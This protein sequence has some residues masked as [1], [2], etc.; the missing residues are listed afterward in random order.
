MP[1]EQRLQIKGLFTHPNELS[2][3]PN[4]A[5]VVADNIVIDEESIAAP[6]RGL[7][8][9]VSVGDTTNKIFEYQDKIIIHYGTASMGYIDGGVLT[10]YSGTFTPV[11]TDTKIKAAEQNENFYFTTQDGIKKLDAFN[12]T[13]LE[14]G[15]PRGLTVEGALT[16]ASGFLPDT[17]QV[18]YR[19]VWGYEDAND[20]LVLGAP[21][22]RVVVSNAAGG[23]RDVDLTVTIP[24]D[25][26]SKFF[27]QIYRSVISDN[28]VDPG[29]ELGLVAEFFP[30]AGELTAGS[31]TYTDSTPDGL[32]G[33]TIYTAPS[34]EGILQ[35]NEQPPRAKDITSHKNFMWYANTVSR[36]RATF[37]I[38]AADGGGAP[39]TALQVD[40]VITIAGT[41]YTGKASTNVANAEFA[42]STA[43][44]PAQR[45]DETARELVKVI[46]QH[47]GNTSVYAY[48]ISG[49]EDLP[50]QILV[51]E[52]NFGG[53][54]FTISFTPQVVNANPFAPQLPLT[55][56]NDEFKNGLYFSKNEQAEAVPTTNLLFVGSA[57]EEILRV[58][59]LRDSLFVLKED[60]IY[61]VT[62]ESA[63]SFRVDLFDNTA[64]LLGPET[65]VSISNQIMM[66]SDQGVISVTETGVTV[67]SRPIEKDLLA[68]LGESRPNVIKY[69][70]AVS[71]ESERKYIF[72]TIRTSA[73]SAATQSY[74]YNVFTNSWT[75]WDYGGSTGFV[76]ETNVENDELFIGSGIFLLKERKSL[77]YKDFADFGKDVEITAVNNNI[78]TVL[79]PSGIER[80]DILWQTDLLFSI[81]DSVDINTGEITLFYTQSFTVGT[82]RRIY[83][84]I[85]C[86]I[87]WVPFTGG[88]PGMR[89]HHREVSYLF[90]KDITATARAGFA[91]DISKN[92]EY[93]DIDAPQLFTGWGLFPWGGAPW[94]GN[95]LRR[96]IRTYIPLE[97]QRCSQLNI[98]FVHSIGFSQFKLSGLTVTFE[99]NSERLN[100]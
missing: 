6:R 30:T 40:D 71:Y 22:E 8:R 12:G 24:D 46:N 5:L 18:A 37:T 79:D 93:V 80:G 95:S 52:R 26:D 10:A 41:D 69:S 25:I 16:G 63:T 78:V 57:Q 72:S 60:G 29:E 48:Y 90:K 27:L 35:A 47:T 33:A 23:S 19:V 50:G 76:V 65:A 61:R 55:S 2:E 11:D 21:S 88:N 42:V 100:K 82:G 32:T 45:I 1:Q 67:I 98:K 97:K 9:F 31:L 49:A 20:S 81:V 86:E 70:F 92:F 89:D 51:E 54:A 73:D 44:T 99:P 85:N 7:D 68:L 64:K 58:I 83:K 13:V 3:V 36:H 53:A 75:R 56:T 38:L 59:E 4:G 96:A 39:G 43:A 17:K 28:T 91:S 34:Q 74:V 66:F 14:A 94:G 87:E 62:G 77:T 15:A 84:A